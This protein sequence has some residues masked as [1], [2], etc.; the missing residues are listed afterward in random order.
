MNAVDHQALFPQLLLPPLSYQE[1]DI[2]PL[3]DES[4]S[5]ITADSAGSDDQNAQSLH[6]P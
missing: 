2:G 3:F 1:S 4:A 6:H 5:E